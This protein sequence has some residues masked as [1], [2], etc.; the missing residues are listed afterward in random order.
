MAYEEF[1]QYYSQIYGERWPL[2]LESLLRKEKQVA[3]RNQFLPALDRAMAPAAIAGCFEWGGGEI[4]RSEENLLEYYIM[5]PASVLAAR[6]LAVQ[7]GDVVLDMCAAPGG[8]MLI[9][10]EALCSAGEI[11]GNEISVGRRERLKKV[12]QQYI[13][14]EVRNRVWLTGKDGGLFAI[15]AKE[16]FDRVL[17][18]APCSGE[19]HLLQ[20]TTEMKEWKINR[21][22]KLAQRQHALLTAALEA[23]KIGGRIVYSTCSISPLENDQVVEK[24]LE[25]KK[26]RLRIIEHV[27]EVLGEKTE[28]G[29]QYFPD[30][31]QFGP[32]YFSV[33][34]RIK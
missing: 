1:N 8:K 12:I 7:S 4:P 24:V 18:D 2:L 32:L 31:C 34:E 29:W 30:R 9:L 19:R 11:T 21:T 33:L 17:L 16:K 15:Q 26:G 23:I 13:P 3:R 28:L 22:K 27:P 25:K 14:R 10:A 20:D 5:D 6:A